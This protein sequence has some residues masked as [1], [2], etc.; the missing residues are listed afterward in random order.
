[1]YVSEVII[2]VFDFFIEVKY[3]TL[4]MTSNRVE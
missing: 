2:E 3:L 4:Y 1:M